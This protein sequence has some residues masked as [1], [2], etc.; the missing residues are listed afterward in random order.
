MTNFQ[1]CDNGIPLL[2]GHYSRFDTTTDSSI[3]MLRSGTFILVVCTLG[4]F[5]YHRNSR[6]S[7][8][9]QKPVSC[10]CD[11]YTSYHPNSNQVSFGLLSVTS[12][13]PGIDSIVFTYDTSSVFHFRSAP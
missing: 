4:F 12:Q 13:T 11:I 3:P 9:M 1:S 5:P 6:F 2:C 10:S 7:R 8:S